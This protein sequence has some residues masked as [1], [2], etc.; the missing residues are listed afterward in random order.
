M[1]DAVMVL[2]LLRHAYLLPFCLLSAVLGAIW[3]SFLGVIIDRLPAMIVADGCAD[4]N[5][6]YPPSH[7]T[8]CQ[9][10]LRWWQ[11]I[12][13]LS[14][15]LLRGQCAHCRQPI[16]LL[17]FLLEALS[18]LFFAATVWVFPQPQA[19]LAL[20]LLWSA[21][22]P[23][24]VIDARHMLLPDCLTLPLLWCGLLLNLRGGWLS[25]Q[26]AV[27]GAAAGYV[28]LWLLY[29]GYRLLRGREGI[30]QGDLKL[31]AAFGA[32]LGW[33]VL[34]QLLLFA[35]FLAILLFLLPRRDAA[36][37]QPFGPS[38]CIAGGG[39]FILHSLLFIF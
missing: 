7:C 16:P 36:A 29:W 35:A 27:V 22:L 25:L 34:P 3:G 23:L 5:L 21:L 12:P 6:F 28:F 33:Q 37:A 38:L 14:W 11:N 30:G 31:V 2:T 19:W 39:I 4:K 18:A 24:A 13:L 20:W 32:W 26:D 9:H 1:G 17:W 15:L 10:T 8:H